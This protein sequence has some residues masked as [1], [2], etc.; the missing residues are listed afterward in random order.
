MRAIQ[1]DRI[2]RLRRLR[3]R[4]AYASACSTASLAGRN[5]SFFELCSSRWLFCELARMSLPVPVTRI[6]F[7]MPFCV[8][9]L[10]T[11]R[12]LLDGGRGRG[13]RGGLPAGREDHEEVL[14]LEQR[15][16]LDDRELLRVVRDPVENSP[17]DVLVDHL[18]APEHD[19]HLNFL[20]CF[21][22]LLQTFELRLRS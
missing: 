2:S 20:S 14:A 22:E 12:S 6:R 7:A 9:I 3:S 8:L 15:G 16:A 17:P 19:R 4:K 13:G 21:E 18:A 1:S 10:G 5:S 11:G